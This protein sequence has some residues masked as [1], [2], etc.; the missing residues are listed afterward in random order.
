V[1]STLQV[2]VVVLLIEHLLVE[3][4]T[5]QMPAI[6]LM[7][8]MV[9]VDLVHIIQILQQVRMVSQILVV[10]VELLEMMQEELD[11]HINLATV[12]PA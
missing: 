4:P 10:A 5:Y 12:V 8:D 9:E 6:D 3:I 1:V 7:V 2:E 11:Q